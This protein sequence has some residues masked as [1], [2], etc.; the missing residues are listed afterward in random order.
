VGDIY[1]GSVD[2]VLFK[3]LLWLRQNKHTDART[4]LLTCIVTN[5]V[6]GKRT[7]GRRG[8]EHATANN[9]QG[10]KFGG[11]GGKRR[12]IGGRRGERRIF[13]PSLFELS[14]HQK[15]R[16]EGGI[17]ARE[18]QMWSVREVEEDTRWEVGG[19]VYIPSLP[20]LSCHGVPRT[21]VENPARGSQRSSARKK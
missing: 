6:V 14:C 4:F 17:P 11:Q 18:S 12:K 2:S 7:F 16:L 15:L 21:E 5:F 1:S 19:R 10:C 13:I 20:E 8:Q 9:S 3:E